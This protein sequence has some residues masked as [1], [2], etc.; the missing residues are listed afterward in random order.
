MRQLTWLDLC[1]GLGGASQ[2]AKDRSWRV[3]RVDIDSRFKP[4]IAADVRSL[5]LKRFH[6]DVA[7][8]SPPCTEFTKAGLPVSWACNRLYPSTPSVELAL[9]CWEVIKGADW[10]ILEN[11]MAAR[12][13]LTPLLGPVRATV[14]G[15]CFWGR[16]PCLLPQTRGHKWRLPP[17]PDRAALRAKIPYEIGET[18]CI[19]IEK[20]KESSRH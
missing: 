3:I 1:S 4:D 16:L 19:S 6:I 7:W 2:P 15:H 14:D 20:R 8:A 11:V 5:P 18:I 12:K 9:A 17:S 13:Y 10:P